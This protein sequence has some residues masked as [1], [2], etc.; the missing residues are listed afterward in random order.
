MAA[1]EANDPHI[2]S[3]GLAY[4]VTSRLGETLGKVF[5]VDVVL[6]AFVC[7]L[8]IQTATTRMIFSMARDEVLPFSKHL[9]QVTKSGATA[10]AAILVGVLGTA[11]LLVNLGQSGAFTALTSTCIV[12]LYLAYL[13]VTVPMLIRRMTGWWGR[14]PV[15]QDENGKPLFTLGRFGFVVNLV[16]VL[17]GLGMMVN[18]AW[19]RPEVYGTSPVLQYFALLFVGIAIVGGYFVFSAK[20]RAYRT[21]IGHP[22]DAPSA[23]AHPTGAHPA[24]AHSV[25]GAASEGALR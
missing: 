14:Q 18:L 13:M 10:V 17:F 9:G 20:K 4:V 1:P 8:A 12:L 5:L 7:T 2:A 25:E 24:A 3:G 6:A 19:P 21:A 16:A 11:L 23:G 15:E 22:A